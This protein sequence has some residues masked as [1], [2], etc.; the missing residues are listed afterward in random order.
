M[1]KCFC[2]AL[3]IAACLSGCSTPPTTL[4]SDPGGITLRWGKNA[5]TFD[6]ARQ[7]AAAHCAS[8]GKEARLARDWTDQDMKIARF[9]CR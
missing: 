4:Q 7:I 8:T 6:S 1:L 5:D 2:V 3:G 9:E